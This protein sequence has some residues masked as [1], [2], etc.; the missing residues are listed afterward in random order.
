[1]RPERVLW[2]VVV[3]LALDLT[4]T[5]AAA[6]PVMARPNI[7]FIL[8][9][10][11]GYGDLGCYGQKKIRTPNLDRLAAEGMRFTPH[12]AGSAVCAPSRCV[13]MTGM[14][15]G[16]ASSATTAG[17]SAVREGQEPVPPANAAAAA[18]CCKKHGYATR[19]LRQM[20]A[21][22]GRQHRRPAEAGLRPLVRL[23]LP[24]R[25]AQLL[26]DAP[27]GQRQAGRARTTRS[28]PRTRS[29]PPM[30][31]P[32]IRRATQPSPASEYAPDLI[33]EQALEFVRGQQGPAVLP[34][35]PDHRAA[36]RA[37]G[38]GGFARRIRRQVP[39]D[40]LHRATGATCRTAHRGPPTP[41][42]SRAWTATSARILALVEELGLDEQHDLRLHQ[43]QRPALRP[44]RRHRHGLLRQRGGPCAA[45]KAPSTRAASACRCIVR[46]KGQ[47]RS[48]H[49]QRPRHR[50]RG[51][52]ADAART[53]GAKD[54]TPGGHRRHQLR[55][56]APGREAGAAAVPL[57]R[58][59]RLRGPAE[60]PRG[61]L[62]GDPRGT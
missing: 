52:A 31:I 5:G 36:P 30:P 19:R 53:V 7:V 56:D 57:P 34:L 49:H 55:A 6:E 18:H 16:H 58:V 9:D 60:R 32:T 33:A 23:Q 46:W 22:A 47:H 17:P 13:L 45:A 28:S 40:A 1:M 3:T 12:Y 59:P 50:L 27:L 24:G 41:R 25:R 43:R 29:C 26:P 21:R 4:A 14:H 37:A 61:R 2:F 62:E 8:A 39:R 15:P 10:D 48:R 42:W 38:A 54:T 44:A 35:L 11:L 20:G 51:L